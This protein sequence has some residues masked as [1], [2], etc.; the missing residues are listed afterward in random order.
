MAYF[1]SVKISNEEYEHFEVPCEV[2][3]YIKQLEAYINHPDAS[4]LKEAYPD[5][6]MPNCELTG[7]PKA[8]PND[9]SE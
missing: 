2:Y 8:S 5:R 1:V 6:F 4:R 9:R 7:S 3:M